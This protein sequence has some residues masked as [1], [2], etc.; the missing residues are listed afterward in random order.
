MIR[1]GT[2]R[3][4]S[5]GAILFEYG[6][7]NEFIFKHNPHIKISRNSISERKEPIMKN[8]KL[9]IALISAALLSIT[10][11]PIYAANDSFGNEIDWEEDYGYEDAAGSETLPETETEQEN[12]EYSFSEQVKVLEQ[13]QQ[14]ETTA[15]VETGYVSASLQTPSK[16]WSES[17]IRIAL[18]DGS[19]KE[20][21]WLYRQNGWSGRQELPVGHYTIAKAETADGSYKFTATPSTF[22]LSENA[23]VPITLALGTSKLKV[24]IPDDLATASN[25][26]PE[27][28]KEDTTK[29]A[30]PYVAII[31]TAVTVIISV[32]AASI[33]KI[34]KDKKNGFSNN[35]FN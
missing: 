19:R 25:T 16:D 33:L 27:L 5:P 3:F 23:S 22:D 29:S 13:M 26:T 11:I 21:F 6:R 2:G 18:Y 20:E 24:D 8:R 10:A 34:R 15:P 35:L 14:Y 9:F 31:I 1:D 4:Y 28:P 32:A 17:N 30:I 12:A 7:K